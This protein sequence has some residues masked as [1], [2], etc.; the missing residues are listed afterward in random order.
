[1]DHYEKN[2]T[3][4]IPSSV[5]DFLYKTISEGLSD[6]SISRPSSRYSWGI[7]VPGDDSHT[8]YVWFDALL[9]YIT[10]AGYPWNNSTFGE[11]PADVHLIGKDIFR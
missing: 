9:S 3:F 6:I 5:Q 2:P 1:M 7:S 4:I 11:W 8:I 10:N